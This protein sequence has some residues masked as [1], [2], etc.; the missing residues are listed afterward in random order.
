MRCLDD[1]EEQRRLV[2]ERTGWGCQDS[3]GGKASPRGKGGPRVETSR[4]VGLPNGWEDAAW[5]EFDVGR[6]PR[7]NRGFLSGIRV[8]KGALSKY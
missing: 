8:P 6:R 3:G 4:V 7:E 2:R 1:D 5:V